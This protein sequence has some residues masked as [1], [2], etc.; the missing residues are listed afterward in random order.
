MKRA[1]VVLAALIACKPAPIP[2]LDPTGLP[3]RSDDEIPSP[4]PVV[5]ATDVDARACLRIAELQCPEA[6]NGCLSAFSAA[7]TDGRLVPSTCIA[8][9]LTVEE[10]RAC[11]DA[12]TLTVECKK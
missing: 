2:P 8:G 6:M 5:P 3:P 1:A 4:N 7:R 9:S 12:S 10:V 11:G